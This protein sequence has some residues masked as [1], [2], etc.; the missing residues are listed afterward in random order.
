MADNQSASQISLGQHIVYICSRLLAYGLPLLFFLVAVSFYLKTYDSAQVKITFTQIGGT[1]L[2][3][4]WFTKILVEGRW[5][6]SRKDLVFVAPFIAFLLSGLI[7]YANTSFKGWALEETLRRI[8]YMFIALITI[9]EMRSN[10]RMN[11]L[12]RWLMAAAWVSIGYGVI[13]YIDSRFF[14]VPALGIDRFIWRQAFGHRVFSTFGNPNFYGNF[15][16]IVTPLILASILRGKGSLVRP[17]VMIVVTLGVFLLVDNMKLGFWFP[18][19]DSFRIVYGALVLGLLIVFGITAFRNVPSVG[20]G[21]FLMLFG[22]LFLNLYAT[23]TKGAWMGFVAATSATIFL[24]FEY[25]LHMDE[26]EVRPRIYTPFVITLFVLMGGI[27][28]LDY[29]G[30]VQPFF[31]GRV[32]QMGFNIL[33]LFV[34]AATI[35][36]VVTLIWVIKKPWNLKK[37]I[38]GLLIFFVLAMGSGVLQYAKTRLLSVSFRVFTW[39]ATW[40]MIQLDPIFGNGVGTFKVIY[41]AFRRPEIIVLEGKSNTETDHSEDEYIEVWQD[42]GIIGFGIFLWLII[43]ALACGFKQ[44]RW[45]SNI[46]APDV[47]KKRK[48]LEVENDPRSYEVLGILG[49]YIGALIHWGVDVSIR[50]VSS[51]VFSG[52]LPGLLVAYARNHANPIKDEVRLGYD[53]LIRAGLAFFWFIIILILGMELVPAKFIREGDTSQASIWVFAF[54]SGVLLFVLLEILDRGIKPQ[55]Q[56]PFEEQYGPINPRLWILRAGLFVGV[57]AIAGIGIHHFRNHFLADVH[58][59]LAIFFSKQ[60]IWEKRPEFEAKV[61]KFPPDIRKK[62][63]K[64]GGALEH[65]AEVKKRNPFFPMARYFTGNVYNDQGSQVLQRANQARQKGDMQTAERLRQ[66]ALEMWD[67]G[68]VAYSETKELAPNYVQT[69]HQMGLLNVKR[70][71]A[72]FIWGDP[73]KGE[74]YYDEA[75]KHFRLYNIIDPVFPPNHHR[76]VQILL[77]RKEYDEAKRLYEQAIFHN[78]DTSTAIRT[79]P[80]SHRSG[81]LGVSLAKVYFTEA[82]DKARAKNQ[83]PFQAYPELI[84]EAL[85]WFKFATDLQPDNVDGWKG[86]GFMLERM[87]RHAEAQAA[88]RKALQLSPNDPE[89]KPKVPS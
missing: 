54:L 84:E 81:E 28:V 56:V 78:K 67:K 65:Y 61:M 34:L 8:F 63:R 1:M 64:W 33:W 7:A 12:W 41:P 69:H 68:E 5:P 20:L 75:Y 39:I 13:Q 79:A 52:L 55:R 42:E 27:L 51:G 71:E 37:I 45:Y 48:L 25:F 86:Q 47:G 9:A 87:G 70:A 2:I 85:K 57:V 21:F 10:E 76:M 44:L 83:D 38:Y 16:V 4:V 31:T 43:T 36:S 82:Q 58:H 14:T 49:A 40:E 24:I 59:N 30:F 88:Y 77:R 50:F 35:I 32:Q 26:F 60:A 29:L 22:F 15:L 6:F 11:R 17:F 66:K 18:Y 89:L 73:Q 80:D 19:D 3:F 72:A 46:R 62:Y 23:E 74:A 53:R